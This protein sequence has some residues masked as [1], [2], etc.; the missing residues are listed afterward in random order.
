MSQ[1]HLS[2]RVHFAAAT[3]PA[4]HKAFSEARESIPESGTVPLRRSPRT[5]RHAG[6]P[7]ITDHTLYRPGRYSQP[8]SACRSGEPP[9]RNGMRGCTLASRNAAGKGDSPARSPTPLDRGDAQRT[10]PWSETSP[11]TRQCSDVPL[12]KQGRSPEREGLSSDP[13]LTRLF[14]GAYSIGPPSR[15]PASDAAEHVGSSMR[16]SAWPRFGHRSPA[17][18]PAVRRRFRHDRAHHRETSAR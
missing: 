13:I 16:A 17:R 9:C 8:R 12:D 4:G 10:P 14:P 11:V 5:M 1:A 7:M 18:C 6:R 3:L 15:H 2:H